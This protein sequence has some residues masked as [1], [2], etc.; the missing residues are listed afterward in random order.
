MIFEIT[1]Q[2]VQE[3]EDV[4]SDDWF[5]PY[6]DKLSGA[7]IVTGY[8]GKFSPYD[9]ITRQDAAVICLR[10]SEKCSAK[11]DGESE[12]A[13]KANIASYALEAVGALSANEIMNGDGTN[14][15]PL[16]TLTR[17][18]TAAILCRLKAAL[19]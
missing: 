7:G 5:K 3:Y 17:G 2:D 15:Y 14:F 8:D 11:L 13:D 10:I 12:F 19:K 4:K 16:N 6:V 18:E 9:N 1:S